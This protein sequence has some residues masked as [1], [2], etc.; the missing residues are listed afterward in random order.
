MTFFISLLP[1]PA[2]VLAVILV[3]LLSNSF[4]SHAEV[5][6][7]AVFSSNMVLQRDI[8]I[9]IWGWADKREEISISFLDETVLVRA[10]KNGKWKAELKPVA[11]GGPYEL[12]IK[13]RNEITLSNILM[14]DVWICSGQSNMEW[15]LSASN[16]GG[17]E[18]AKAIH[19]GIRLFTVQKKVSTVPLPDCE[20]EGWVVCSPETVGSFSAVA[21]F[22]GKKLN[23]DLDVPVGLIHTSWGGTNIETWTSA[24]DIEKVTG[25][26][27]V[28]KELEVFDEE[29]VRQTVRA[30]VEAITGPLPEEDMGMEGDK[31]VW[32]GSGMDYSG[33][34][35]MDL[36]QLWESAGL[37]GL[38]G[39][40]WF[41]K[42][43]Q[44]AAS[45]LLNDIEVHLGLIDDADITYL[46]GK[47][48]G[49]TAQYNESRI[50][51]VG[52]QHLKSGKNT[53]VV[54]VEDTGGG[55]GIYGDAKEMFITL[56]NKKISLAGSW[57]YK[58]GRGDFSFSVGPNSMPA[59][60]YNAMI[61][62][63]LPIGIKGA[64]WYQGE[65]NA[66][67]A[68]EYRTLFPTMINSW[69]QAW[70]QGD[71]PFLYVQLANFMQAAE[72]PGE[73]SWAEL[74]EAQTMTLSLPNTGMAT[75]IDIGEANDIHPRNKL[76]VGKRLALSA[77]KVAY[78]LDVVA[79]GPTFREMKIDG[80]K[81]I[82]SFD[83][84]GSGLY[85]KNKYGYIHGFTVAGEDKKFY[86]AK[87]ELADDK[88]VLTC[89]DVQKP[90]AVRYGWADNPDDLNLYNLEGLP[91]VPFRTDSWPGIT[92]SD[93]TERKS[94][95]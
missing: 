34:K 2:K 33:W 54:R 56:P 64:I 7:P 23:Q 63:L 67:K 17:E 16:N 25:F 44:L 29:V 76:D 65:S 53:I 75:I 89:P 40:V 43:F 6:L 27:G 82:L 86:W 92:E 59:L 93:I 35:D 62:P 24:T 4:V 38:D 9:K 85:L 51:K 73:S 30:K 49:K 36:P 83:N 66:G 48:I 20:S 11:A 12:K 45:D 39:I 72:Q 79:S 78:G 52:K 3:L 69:R 74:R 57:K 21:Y 60:L 47:V 37:T 22:F 5:T 28:S 8:P 1:K 13:G 88:I 31:A 55:G 94:G 50:Y 90:V 19:P 26:E 77:L 68:Y 84:V 87:A 42:D 32:A 71:F 46:N 15:P 18:I 41:Q 14:G 91:A 81:V 70:G 80:N 95:R 10:D 58:I 61:H